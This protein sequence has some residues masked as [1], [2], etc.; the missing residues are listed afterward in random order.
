MEDVMDGERSLLGIGVYTVPEAAWMTNVSPPR[1]RRWLRGYKFRVGG[2]THTSSAVWKPDLPVLEDALAL[3]FRD[4]MEVRFVDYFL[5]QGVSWRMLRL[6]AGYAGEI[7]N[8][9]HPFSTKMFKTDGKTIFA[10]F[11]RQGTRKIFNVI[12]HQY[13]IPD[14]IAP[15]LYDGLEFKENHPSRW[16]PL[17]NSKRVVIDPAISFGQPVVN[18]E[19][20]PTL[21]L[22]RAFEVEK[23]IDRV[24][25]WYNVP[26]KSVQDAVNYQQRLAA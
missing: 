4:L 18:P 23:N 7:V 3:S 5:K 1:I 14:F 22:A 16:F 15:Y 10:D 12:K 25:Y 19:G 8:S 9:T 6:A 13:T 21:I 20:V 24:S 17:C 26:K 2:K 11:E